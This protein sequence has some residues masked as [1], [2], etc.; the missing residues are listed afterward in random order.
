MKKIAFLSVVLVA[1]FSIV[2]CEKEGQLTKITTNQI[3][4]TAVLKFS[5][6]LSPT[7]GISGGGNVK[8]SLDNGIYKL[9]L[10]NYTIEN[11]P[12]LKVY[13][14]KTASTTSDFVNLG[15]ATASTVYTI[16]QQADLSV[17][18]YVLIHCQQYNHLFATAALTQN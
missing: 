13:L 7:S 14:S 3:S 1:V 5:G 9:T 2:S 17:Y 4:A 10:E 12:D 15:N 6:V 8:I 16:P 18:K 11:G